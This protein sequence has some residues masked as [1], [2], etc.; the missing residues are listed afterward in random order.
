[1]SYGVLANSSIESFFLHTTISPYQEMKYNL[2]N[3]GSNSEGF[4]RV[5]NSTTEQYAYIGDAA[6]LNY[7]RSQYCNLT[8]VGNFKE[9]SLGLAVPKE[10]LYWKEISIQILKL[11]EEGFLDKLGAK[12][13]CE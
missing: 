6:L 10:S 1:M 4:K 7:A 12:W 3:V 8:T 5:L 13:Y 9:D 2:K 11:R